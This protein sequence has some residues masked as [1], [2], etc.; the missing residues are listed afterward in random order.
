[1][2]EKGGLLCFSGKQRRPSCG[3]HGIV[4]WGSQPLKWQCE[5]GRNKGFIQGLFLS[6]DGQ[7]LAI[8]SS[9]REKKLNMLL[10]IATASTEIS[11]LSWALGEVPLINHRGQPLLLEY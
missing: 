8:G 9:S 11:E 3:V 5:T 1:M 6:N 2:L 4:Y 10:R 7:S